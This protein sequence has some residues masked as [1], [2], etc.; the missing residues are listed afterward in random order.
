M[1][2]H[3]QLIFLFVTRKKIILLLL[4]SILLIANYKHFSLI[5]LNCLLLIIIFS[6]GL[7]FKHSGFKKPENYY[8]KFNYL[9]TSQIKL[10]KLVKQ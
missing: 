10:N 2:K 6:F 7:R 1:C 9:L 3:R 4:A 8:S 5:F